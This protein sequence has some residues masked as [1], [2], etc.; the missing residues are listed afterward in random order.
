LFTGGGD[1]AGEGDEADEMLD[2]LVIQRR[3]PRPVDTWI[4]HH[5]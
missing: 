5:G 3:N 1:G 2:I 4:P